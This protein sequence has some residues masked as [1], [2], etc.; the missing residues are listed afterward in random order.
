MGAYLFPLL[1]LQRFFIPALIGYALWAIWRT[2]LRKDMAV[3]LALYLALVVIVDGFLNTGIFLPGMEKGSIRYSEVCA[4]F[5][6]ANR[7]AFQSDSGFRTFVQFFVSLYFLLLVV[8]VFRSSP[9]TAGIFEF[10]RLIIPQLL[11]L[12]IARRGLGS[13]EE[14][15]RFFFALSLVVLICAVFVFWDVFFDRLLLKSDMIYKPEYW[16]NRKHGRFGGFFLNPNLMGA[17]VALV[18]PPTFIQALN[19]TRRWPRRCAWA[20][21][22][23][24]LFCLVETQSRAPL[25]SFVGALILLSFGPC[26]GMSKARRIGFVVLLGTVF[27]TAMPGFYKHAVERFSSLDEESSMEKRS[28]ESVWTFTEKIIADHPLAGVGFGEQQYINAMEAYGFSEMFHEAPLDNPHNSYLQMTVYAGF[29]ALIV[30]LIANLALLA[31]G[32]VFSF[33]SS[34]GHSPI[35]FGLTVAIAGFLVA[36]YPDMH[37]FTQNVS[38]VYWTMF[39][40]L[41]G[42]LTNRPGTVA[43]RAVPTKVRISGSRAR[44]MPAAD[45]RRAGAALVLEAGTRADVEWRADGAT[46]GHRPQR[47]ERGSVRGPAN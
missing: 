23:G 21:L 28:R 17:F 38:T 24:L 37:L 1:Q 22:L 31:G 32:A 39:G 18:F 16:T 6:L 2:A 40:L 15:R 34:G 14:Y 33:R 46:R 10:R 19:E 35:V 41:C 12:A 4:L 42:A 7:P 25:I 26:G 36:C 30:F 45:G 47:A 43:E 3:G 5:L 20:A 27:V 9:V 8:S 29:P 44:S 11:A 13:V